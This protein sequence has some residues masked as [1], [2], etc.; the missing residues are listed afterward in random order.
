MNKE[1]LERLVYVEET[2]AGEFET[3]QDPV[4]K[5]YYEVPISIFRDWDNIEEI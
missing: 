1:I 3:Y 5:K 4:T 2:Y